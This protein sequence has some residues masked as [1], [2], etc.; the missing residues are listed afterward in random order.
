MTAAD[1]YGPL[2]R[3]AGILGSLWIW[4]ALI[5]RVIT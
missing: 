3:T 1:E 2:V 5:G 4:V